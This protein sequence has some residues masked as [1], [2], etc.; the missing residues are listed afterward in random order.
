MVAAQAT[1]PNSPRRD[2]AGRGL[3]G[4][5]AERQLV[6]LS[7]RTI[8]GLEGFAAMTRP[9]NTPQIQPT[10]LPRQLTARRYGVNPRTIRRWE[11]EL[12]DFPSPLV[13]NRRIYDS[14][15]A[16]DEWDRACAA[17]GRAAAQG[18]KPGVARRR[19]NADG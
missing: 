1:A 8:H 11:Q 10:W 14:I 9:K 6:F 2:I 4:V 12:P 18:T 19:D 5:D 13:R 7:S 17:A 3:A 16:L 15:Q